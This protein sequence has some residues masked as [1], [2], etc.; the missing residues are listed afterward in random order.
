MNKRA[1]I[2]CHPNEQDSGVQIMK[3]TEKGPH[4]QKIANLHKFDKN[5][6]KFINDFFRY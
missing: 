3:R 4:Y 1:L 2:N 5:I 6:H